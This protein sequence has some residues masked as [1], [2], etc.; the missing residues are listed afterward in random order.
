MLAFCCC[1]EDRGPRTR[2]GGTSCS[3][4]REKLAN[5]ARSRSKRRTG[6]EKDPTPTQPKEQR[7]RRGFDDSIRGI[8]L[9]SSLC[10]IGHGFGLIT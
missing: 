2:R 8:P 5:D 7:E 4:S 1:A 6:K 3:R 10:K 9:A